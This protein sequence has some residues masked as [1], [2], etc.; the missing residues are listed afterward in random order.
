MFPEK[1]VQCYVMGGVGGQF[2]QILYLSSIEYFPK[3]T[4]SDHVGV[5]KHS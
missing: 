1:L 2:P 3:L 5:P 4:D